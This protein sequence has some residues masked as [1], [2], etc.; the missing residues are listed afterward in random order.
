MIPGFCCQAI[1]VETRPAVAGTASGGVEFARLST[2]VSAPATSL[3][4]RVVANSW[5]DCPRADVTNPRPYSV[6]ATAGESAPC[7]PGVARPSGW[8]TPSYCDAWRRF[9]STRD[10][11]VEPLVSTSWNTTAA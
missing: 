2:R 3:V 1:K 11:A 10:C 6:T 4:L 8:V 7:G 9:I 5:S